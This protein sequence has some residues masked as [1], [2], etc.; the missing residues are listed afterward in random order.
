MVCRVSE[1]VAPS[2]VYN[3]TLVVAQKI[4]KVRP[5]WLIHG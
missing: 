3:T 1:L 5:V 2:S 4:L